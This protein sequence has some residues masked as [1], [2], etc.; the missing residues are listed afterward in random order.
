MGK[1]H[2]IMLALVPVINGAAE[3]LL[4]QHAE[5]NQRYEEYEKNQCALAESLYEHINS[6]QSFKS[7]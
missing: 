4:D 6:F 7:I 1:H 5:I 3:L 2:L